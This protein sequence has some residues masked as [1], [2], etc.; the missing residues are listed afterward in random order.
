MEMLHER[1]FT[2]IVLRALR[3]RSEHDRVFTLIKAVK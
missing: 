3:Q 2:Q 1:N